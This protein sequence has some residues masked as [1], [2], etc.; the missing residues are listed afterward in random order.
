MP[1]IFFSSAWSL[2]RNIFHLQDGG[3]YGS[4]GFAKDNCFRD[5][6]FGVCAYTHLTPRDRKVPGEELRQTGY[7]N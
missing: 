4:Q 1:S 3:G 2:F 7:H 6:D 5:S